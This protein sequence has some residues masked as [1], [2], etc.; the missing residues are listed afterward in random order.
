MLVLNILL[1]LHYVGISL[2]SRI[3][4]GIEISLRSAFFYRISMGVFFYL[5]RVTTVMKRDLAASEM[6]FCAGSFGQW[7]SLVL[8]L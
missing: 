2:Y 7:I 8:V 3:G 5:L 6:G 1:H 4:I